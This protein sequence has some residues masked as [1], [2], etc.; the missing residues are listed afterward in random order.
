[1]GFATA[2]CLA[3][4]ETKEIRRKFLDFVLD[5]AEVRRLQRS[6]GNSTDHLYSLNAR[7]ELLD[8]KL[9]QLLVGGR[10]SKEHEFSFS[11]EE[12]RRARDVR[13]S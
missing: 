12:I 2:Y 6:G 5:V 1:M 7:E 10:I 9:L 11:K 13:N 4:Q 8:D 3:S